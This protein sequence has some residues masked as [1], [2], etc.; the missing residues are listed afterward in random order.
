M[1]KTAHWK[2]RS[3]PEG[4]H[5]FDRA[6]GTNVLMDEVRPL[7]QTWAR[8]PRYVSFALTNACDLACSYCYAPKQGA[9]LDR[10]RLLEWCRELDANGCFGVGFG[11]GEP[12]LYPKFAALCREVADTTNLAVTF[13]THSHRITPT[14]AEEFQGSVNFIR[15]S[16]DGVDATYERLRGRSFAQLGEQL[17]LIGSIC[18]FGINVVVNDDTIDELDALA[19]FASRY[20]ARELLLLPEQPTPT[21]PGITPDAE[22]QMVTWIAGYDGP[23]RLAVSEA[24]ADAALPIADPFADADPLHS[25]AHV[26]AFGKLSAN[27]F[28]DR[29]VRVDGSV[30]D[31]LE[32]L[33]S[34][35]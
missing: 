8:A 13:T 14:M 10:V 5:F 24:G 4:I 32:H 26:N 11:G 6:T 9:R 28:S 22:R 35:P 16:V 20:D 31:A 25:H 30:L 1:T 29:I 17:R 2:R 27:A 12:T 33:R 3:G 15:V 18:T 21:A 19:A 34:T 23:M 7:T